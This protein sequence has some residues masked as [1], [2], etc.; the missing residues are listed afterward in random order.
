MVALDSSSN[1]RSPLL[2]TEAVGI[3]TGST[4]L[5]LQPVVAGRNEVVFSALAGTSYYIKTAPASVEAFSSPPVSRQFELAVRPQ[6]DYFSNRVALSG[7]SISVTGDTAFASSEP[8]QPAVTNAGSRTLWWT[9]TAPASGWVKT[10]VEAGFPNALVFW[11]GEAFSNLVQVARL[12][13]PRPT[14]ARLA[15]CDFSVARLITVHESR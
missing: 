7:G 12:T 11:K 5:S 6:N 1:Q 3:Y 4:L 13:N 2:T 14:T 8:N 15:R 9:W 10:S